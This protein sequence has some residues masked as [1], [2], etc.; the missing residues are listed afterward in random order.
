[1]TPAEILAEAATRGFRVSLNS[2][3]DGLILWPGDD[4]P[5]DLVKLLKAHKPDIVARLQAERGR[6]NHW[7]AD[8]IISW[9]PTHCLHCRKPIVPGQIWTAVTNGDAT[10]RFHQTCHGDWLAQ[11]EVAARK[12][13]GLT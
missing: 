9:P 8:K 11:Q 5:S 13:I 7:I 10:A 2:T 6:I 3:G 1:M 12:A 4:P